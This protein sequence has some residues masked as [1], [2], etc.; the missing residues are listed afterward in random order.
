[1]KRLITIL[2]G[3]A[4]VCVTFSDALA[5][6][7]IVKRN[8]NVRSDHSSDKPPIARLF[9]E[10]EVELIEPLPTEKYFHVR[11]EGG[12]EGWVYF[13]NLEIISEEPAAPPPDGAGVPIASTN[14]IG[15]AT[16]ISPDWEKPGPV[17]NTF[18]SEDGDC[19]PIGDGGDELTN[20][21]KNRTDVPT[22]Y[23]P[24]TWS[25]LRSLSY[26]RA[27]KSLETW[28]SQELSL[29]NPYQGIAVS[30][31]G[32]LVAVKPQTHGRGEYTNCHFTSADEVDWHMALAQNAGDPEAK[33][34]VVETTP[35]IRQSHAK[36]TV[37]ALAPWIK[38]TAPVRISGWTM[39]DP[40]HRNHLGRYRSTLWEI[41]PITKIEVFQDGQWIDLD[42]LP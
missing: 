24:V 8:T 33:A 28:T 42:E 32:Y 2:I 13:R 34:I 6:D 7:A 16:V 27:G 4:F 3:I 25:A 19:G 12:V 26:P 14:N 21:R 15:I 29:I 38:T 23:H 31:V 39:F 17:D 1:M 22:Q 30:I 41:H 37:A 40:A 35:R 36:W 10:E 9:P 18:H 20:A 11:T 5:I